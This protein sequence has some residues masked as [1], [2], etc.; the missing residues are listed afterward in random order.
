MSH[1]WYIAGHYLTKK[2]R[3]QA[4]ESGYERAARNLRKQGV[5]LCISLYILTGKL[6]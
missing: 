4:L 2:A 6:A 1:I 5:P 3:A